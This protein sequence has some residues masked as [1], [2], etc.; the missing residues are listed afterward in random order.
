MTILAIDA[1]IAMKWVLREED[2]ETAANLLQTNSLIAPSFLQLECA[3]AL[4]ASA[5][6]KIIS[7]PQ[8]EAGLKWIMT[9]P[10]RWTEIR[11]CL[12]DAASI[13]VELDR[14]VYDSLYLAVAISEGASLVTAD[15]RFAAAVKAHAR[16]LPF[17]HRLRDLP[18]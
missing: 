7:H 3:N 11:P 8:A 13:A 10:V 14:T 16:Y 1:S 5:R 18:A 15:D 4:W 12:E 9:A 17:V 6:R 2:S